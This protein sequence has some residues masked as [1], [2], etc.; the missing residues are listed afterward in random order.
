MFVIFYYFYWRSKFSFDDSSPEIW[1]QLNFN[2]RDAGKILFLNFEKNPIICLFWFEIH[3]PHSESNHV[4]IMDSHTF[5]NKSLA[6][7]YSTTHNNDTSKNLI[8]T[9][10]PCIQNLQLLRILYTQLPCAFPQIIENGFIEFINK[11]QMLLAWI[12]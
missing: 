7:H 8:P 12:F 3:I 6:I 9:S 5:G 4:L 2:V 11:F 1:I 10:F